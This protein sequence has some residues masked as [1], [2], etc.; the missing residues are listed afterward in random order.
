MRT[1]HKPKPKPKP[2][3]KRDTDT[4]DKQ[5]AEDEVKVKLEVKGKK[6]SMRGN[7]REVMKQGRQGILWRTTSAD[8]LGDGLGDGDEG[9]P[10]RET[11]EEAEAAEGE[12][13]EEEEEE[14]TRPPIEEE[15]QPAARAC[16]SDDAEGIQKKNKKKEKESDLLEDQN[17]NDDND[18]GNERVREE[19]EED[20]R[21]SGPSGVMDNGEPTPS[22]GS[23][24]SPGSPDSPDSLPGAAGA[25]GGRRLVLLGARVEIRY[26]NPPQYFGALVAEYKG[27]K[28][29]D[30]YTLHYD[31]GDVD[32]VDLRARDTTYRIISQPDM[33]G[34]RLEVLFELPKPATFYSGTVTGYR[35][36][37]GMYHIEYDD[38][39]EEELDL[40]SHEV[41]YRLAP[42]SD[43][44]S[45]S[46]SPAKRGPGR[47]PKKRGRPP[48][49]AKDDQ[50]RKKIKLEVVDEL[51]KP[52]GR[53]RPPKSPKVSTIASGGKG[54]KK[55]KAS[56]VKSGKKA[57]VKQENQGKKGWRDGI[58]MVGKRIEVFFDKPS[59][60]YYPAKV[61]EYDRETKLFAIL[62]DDGVSETLNLFSKKIK[63]R[64]IQ[65]AKQKGKKQVLEKSVA[66]V[67][68]KTKLVNKVSKAK[69]KREGVNGHQ[70]GAPSIDVRSLKGGEI[71]WAKQRGCPYWPAEVLNDNNLSEEYLA[72]RRGDSEVCVLFFGHAE[73]NEMNREC[74]WVS[75]VEPFE[76]NL[77][78][79]K[80][81]K[82]TISFG[83]A[84]DQACAA[85]GFANSD[86]LVKEG[87]KKEKME[88]KQR[89]RE[90]RERKE[91]EEKKKKEEIAVIKR[92]SFGLR[93]PKPKTIEDIGYNPAAE[94][95]PLE[96]EIKPKSLQG[97]GE[98]ETEEQLDELPL[99]TFAVFDIVWAKSKGCPFWPAQ[100]LDLDQLPDAVKR[101]K[102]KDNLGVI[103]L[104]PSTNKKNTRDFGWVGKGCIFPFN[105]YLEKF[106]H[107][108]MGRGHKT[109]SFILAVE[110]AM[111]ILRGEFQFEEEAE[112]P[113][114]PEGDAGRPVATADA[115][116]TSPRCSS[117]GCVMKD[118]KSFQTR[119]WVDLCR[120]CK[121]AYESGDFC[122][123]CEA[124]YMPTEKDM[125]C[126]DSCNSWIHGKCD[127]E[128][129][130]VIKDS[131][132]NPEKDFPYFCA[133][134]REV[135]EKHGVNKTY[136]R[137]NFLNEGSKIQ[138]E[139]KH[140]FAYEFL[141]D[142]RKRKKCIRSINEEE[143]AVKSAWTQL[144]PSGQEEYAAK[145]AEKLRPAK[146][147][148][149]G[150]K[151]DSAKNSSGKS[152]AAPL[153][154]RR[155]LIGPWN[156]VK[157]RTFAP[158]RARWA[159]D[160]CA[161][162]NYDHDF[163][164]DQFVTCTSCG[165][166]VHQSCY[167][168]LERPALDDVWLCRACEKHEKG[169]MKPQCCVC[170]IEGGA[171]KPTTLPGYWCHVACMQWMP[172]L[173]CVDVDRMEPIDRVNLIH[174]QRW[175]H[176]CSIC[177]KEMGA[178]IQCDCC[179]TAFHPLC[180]R[181][182][183]FEMKTQMN[184][185]GEIVLKAYCARHSTV[186]KPGTGLLP[187]TSER[188][189][190]GEKRMTDPSQ[191]LF[192]ITMPPF[193]VDCPSGC[194]RCEP[195]HP[196]LGWVREDK[197]SGRG[198]SS[199]KGFWI[200]EPEV[201]P[202]VPS[203]DP[204]KQSKEKKGKSKNTSKPRTPKNPVYHKSW[205]KTP[206]PLD[207]LPVGCPEQVR[208]CCGT[209]TGT[210]LVR[211]QNI[212]YCGEEIS[213][214][215]FEIIGGKGHS[216]KWKR[217]V[218]AC[219]DKWNP[220]MVMEDWLETQNLN[221][222]RLLNLRLNM[223]RREM[224]Q[225][226]K[227][228]Q[229]EQQL[230]E[231]VEK[232]LTSVLN[233]TVLQLQGSNIPLG[234]EESLI[235]HASE[236]QGEPCVSGTPP[237]PCTPEPTAPERAPEE[238]PDK[239]L[240][241]DI[242]AKM[243]EQV[244]DQNKGA[245]DVPD[246]E[247]KSSSGVENNSKSMGKEEKAAYRAQLGLALV[248]ESLQVLW[249]E[250]N[251][252]N[253]AKV[254]AYNEE[255]NMHKIEYEDK[256]SREWISLLHEKIKWES[257]VCDPPLPQPSP[258]NDNESSH[259]SFAHCV[260]QHVGVWWKDDN[261]FYY[262]EV[263]GYNPSNGHC[264]ILYTE[265]GV[266]EWLDFNKEKLDWSRSAP[267]AEGEQSD[268]KDM[269]YV[270]IVCNGLKA[271]LRTRTKLVY[272][273][274][275]YIP[276]E[277]FV[278]VASGL[279]GKESKWKSSIRILKN[280]DSVGQTIGDWLLEH[281]FDSRAVASSDQRGAKF[282]KF[283]KK[284]K[285][286]PIEIR[287]NMS[288]RNR[289]TKRPRIGKQIFV[290]G[291]AYKVSS[292]RSGKKKNLQYN[293]WTG[294]EWLAKFRP[295]PE[296]K[297]AENASD[298]NG[299]SVVTEEDR[300]VRAEVESLLEG[301]LK[302][303]EA[304]VEEEEAKCRSMVIDSAAEAKASEGNCETE[305]VSSV[306]NLVCQSVEWRMHAGLISNKGVVGQQVLL[307]TGQDIKTIPRAERQK[308]ACT[309]I[310]HDVQKC[311]IKIDKQGSVVEIPY[312]NDTILWHTLMDCT[313]DKAL[314][315]K[316]FKKDEST[317]QYRPFVYGYH[318]LD[319]RVSVLWPDNE[320]FY[321]GVVDDFNHLDDRHRIR[322]DDG[323]CEW[324]DLKK[325]QTRWLRKPG[326]YKRP[327]LN[328]PEQLNIV[329]NGMRG[330]FHVHT[331]QVELVGSTGKVD[332]VE[333][334]ADPIADSAAAATNGTHGPD[335]DPE[336]AKLLPEISSIV[337]SMV[338][339]A[340]K[341]AGQSEGQ[342]DHSSPVTPLAAP[343]VDESP[344]MLPVENTLLQAPQL[345]DT[346]GNENIPSPESEMISVEEFERRARVLHPLRRV[347]KARV[348]EADGSESEYT[349]KQWLIHMNLELHGLAKGKVTA[350]EKARRKKE[351]EERRK[352][353]EKKK[354]KK[355]EFSEP[356]TYDVVPLLDQ[357]SR[358]A[359]EE[360]KTVTF[361]K[362]AIHGWGLFSK[363]AIKEGE[364]VVE[365]RGDIVRHSVANEREERYRKQKKD[366]YLFAA[367]NQQVIDSTDVGS[368]GRF[369]N[370]S[371]APSCY[372][373]LV[374]DKANGIPHLGFFARCDILPGQELTFDYRL[375]E[376]DDDHKIE[377]KCG[378][379]TC[380]GTM[381]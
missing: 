3:P 211:S 371:C 248:G 154:S 54:A 51:P 297:S 41:Q 42:S 130:K 242:V 303:V 173:T 195:L 32:V 129:A 162:C 121:K 305:E 236:E 91:S 79:Y 128:A 325:E 327:K 15:P 26:D 361:G 67:T 118:G 293:A 157:N 231:E 37:S 166:T 69:V 152:F 220:V 275:I 206:V 208:V 266:E 131:S 345:G 106:R 136:T 283:G 178:I 60:M 216:K 205:P 164:E 93:A 289:A 271:Y 7:G 82:K 238:D 319:W 318:C 375:R 314:I 83:R 142:A 25:T 359:R 72:Q 201:V 112:Q 260:G 132:L 376:E 219:D 194:S 74:A 160:H 335:P 199:S 148:K 377:C 55:Q 196:C 267:D 120:S 103:Y 346:G 124:L 43:S 372:I 373:K 307:N 213:A 77:N 344:L 90:E 81:A 310:A 56:S 342:P 94:E 365:Y 111:K 252:W 122:K 68:K 61:Q 58:G 14:N 217:T 80:D 62:Y 151:R 17:N 97:T 239:Q 230:G 11:E 24:G 207:P 225:E 265:D 253:L 190:Q 234:K 370:H 153:K 268:L 123:V 348:L 71:V 240:V 221:R 350:E 45:E 276:P 88:K 40:L 367:N 127:P 281:G 256:D 336:A 138:R 259:K 288:A 262:G 143:E 110:E 255:H 2:R 269:S 134:C 126:C 161:V 334:I 98:K 31:D 167:G 28:G 170:P 186:L 309:V 1:K 254:I 78:K 264:H 308:L 362:S 330:I 300:A 75:L 193:E 338:D 172:E 353:K 107:Q 210:L 337:K 245:E 244:V 104:G 182:Q 247:D 343:N 177:K 27:K 108:K 66:S 174:K 8:G 294:K 258:E 306:L 100:I 135:F 87:I 50:D 52:K 381:N 192:H 189:M 295:Q 144:G 176:K 235:E 261:R 185:D 312:G 291:L 116:S 317:M 363:I 30:V 198:V 209:V 169:K 183:G 89:E 328:I 19:G 39:D 357:I 237:A 360:G 191:Y 340:A 224:Y 322:Y 155:K 378:A 168:V 21:P 311:M 159:K 273:S 117:C 4:G 179:F 105:E 149:V 6:D 321:L 282:N 232:V 333:E 29:E 102:R 9:A 368:I 35:K 347:I 5:G 147:Q 380:R 296:G 302:V 278:E 115:D 251:K 249:S 119:K 63:Y 274:G 280:D 34:K 326:E 250:F 257:K 114:K 215:R 46:G 233:Q 18:G 272:L 279:S 316:L 57:K 364:A 299:N 86:C 10:P 228:F 109:S 287:P 349:V 23:P 175:Q 223:R 301:M 197:G 352:K 227:E 59:P 53:G 133:I 270:A 181:M 358:C 92:A 38:G 202:E 73:G 290:R 158:I 36:E 101:L 99:E 304:R 286:V 379:P 331:R 140:Q 320:T 292:S 323:S 351:V 64:E 96:A 180:A 85:L 48:K 226:W 315:E 355:V 16:A 150:D 125:V 212:Q 84:V 339:L 263:Q 241:K 137:L 156:V 20:L 277:V 243:F 12:E 356:A 285:N 13:K 49:N 95:K 366:L 139:V 298:T 214:P 165:I 146:K 44:P 33:V 187:A 203:T 171:L 324:L 374:E 218:W 76:E 229:E 332:Q 70:G 188:E 354:K 145:V 113:A 47:P 341:L 204:M 141:V 284:R 369:M 163:D 22:P 184:E 246:V 222:A 329:S 200:P 65:K 313:A